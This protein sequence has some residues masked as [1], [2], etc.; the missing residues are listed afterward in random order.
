MSEFTEDQLQD[1][2]VRALASSGIHAT[3]ERM[4]KLDGL[5]TGTGDTP[6]LVTQMAIL[7]ERVEQIR[8]QGNRVESFM[9]RSDSDRSSMMQALKEMEINHFET[10]SNLAADTERLETSIKQIDRELRPIIEWKNRLTPMIVKAGAI[11]AAISVVL[12]TVFG[13]ILDHF[14]VIRNFA[15]ALGGG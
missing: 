10:T 5:I 15:R 12:G 13:F 7:S 2:L 9:Q 8:H 11:T 4:A 1:A 14:A 6:G 3:A